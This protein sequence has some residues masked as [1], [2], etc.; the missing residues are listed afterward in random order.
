MHDMVEID[1]HKYQCVFSFIPDKDVV[2][3]IEN[4]TY[5]VQ[6]TLEELKNRG[7]HPLMRLMYRAVSAHQATCICGGTKAGT[8]HSDWCPRY[9]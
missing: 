3:R 4:G 7:S 8:P 6:Y 2:E 9:I 1:G 5:D